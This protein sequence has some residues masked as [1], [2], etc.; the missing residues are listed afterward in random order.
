MLAL[1]FLVRGVAAHLATVTA[2]TVA[3]SLTLAAATL[4]CVHVPEPPV[5]A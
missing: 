3:H 4:G 5:E 1:L 2:F